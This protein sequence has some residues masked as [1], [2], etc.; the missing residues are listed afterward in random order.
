[1][2]C[3]HYYYTH[4]ELQETHTFFGVVAGDGAGDGAGDT[5]ADDDNADGDV[6]DVTLTSPTLLSSNAM[7][8]S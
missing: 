7:L 6:D 5:L 1:M 8:I 3:C 2:P 4:K